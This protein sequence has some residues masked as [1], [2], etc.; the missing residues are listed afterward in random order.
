M[1][2]LRQ[3]IM[4]IFILS[5]FTIFVFRCG[6]ERDVDRNDVPVIIDEIKIE[7]N[8]DR[9]IILTRTDEVSGLLTPSATEISSGITYTIV[10][11]PGGDPCTA[12]QVDSKW[13]TCCDLQITNNTGAP[14]TGAVLTGWQNLE[15]NAEAGRSSGNNS[16]Y[17]GSGTGWRTTDG[18]TL[19]P[20]GNG[21]WVLWLRGNSTDGS[22]PH[23]GASEL[24]RICL[25][26]PTGYSASLWKLYINCPVGR[27]KE[28][29]SN[30]NISGWARLGDTSPDPNYPELGT[31]NYVLTDT[32][33][34]FAFPEI[35][36][37]NFREYG[38]A[39][40][41]QT[42]VNDTAEVYHELVLPQG[43]TDCWI[44]TKKD[45]STPSGRAEHTALWTGSEMIIWGGLSTTSALNTGGKYDPV[46]DSWIP[47][48]LTNAPTGR[49]LHTAV[50][51]GSEM[52]IWGGEGWLN[53][54]VTNTGGRYSPSTDSWIP[55]ST[56]N[57]P[58]SRSRHTA[59]WTGSEMIVW[60]G[61][62]ASAA[63]NSGGR[64]NPLSDSWTGT[65]TAGAPAARYHHTA[66]WTGSIM[67]VWGGWDGSAIFPFNTGGRYNPSTNT[68]TSTA[69]TGAPS[70]RF[71]HTA[72]WTGSEMVVWGGNDNFSNVLNTGGRYNPVSN[73]WSATTTTGAPSARTYHTA[74]WTGG[75]M[76][77]W[78]GWDNN[79]L[80][81]TGG[82]YDPLLNSW[83]S[84][85]LS[86]APSPRRL[87]SGVWTGTVMIIWGGEDIP[88]A[89][90]TGGKY[91]P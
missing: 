47:I 2:P 7:Q 23:N 49:H 9:M 63:Y 39:D 83:V 24:R 36:A 81:N 65:P 59:V 22:I 8:F 38:G 3:K 44:P 29:G 78:G 35:T 89:G 37:T 11:I 62:G 87:H 52:I 41:H 55:T 40:C 17:D 27:L 4:M 90:D 32:D 45:G 68:W 34:Y 10:G 5:A 50:W 51:T 20:A 14:I 42:T 25:Q 77:V 74:V 66:V 85:S 86:N 76:V 30:N 54:S 16:G 13:R 48:S 19:N 31:G 75:N 33:G 80:L 84:T 61:R 70:G 69:T 64:Y 46:T 15:G 12:V 56:T 58:L 60:G 79:N 71:Y 21:G 6:K 91:W 67:V 57:A 26:S 53:G 82:R 43:G 72:V 1:N 88:T 73:T 18:N 28:G